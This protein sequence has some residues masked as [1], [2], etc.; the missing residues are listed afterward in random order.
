[1]ILKLWAGACEYITHNGQT[2]TLT[3]LSSPDGL[4][5]LHL[6]HADGSQS[7]NYLHTD[8]T[9]TTL[10]TGLGSWTTVTDETGTIVD[11]QSYD[12]WGNRRNPTTW[13][14]S[15]L[16]QAPRYDRGFTGHEH[17]GS[18]QLINP[19]ALHFI[20][21]SGSATANFSLHSVCEN[22]ASAGMNGRMYDPVTSRMLAPDNFVQTPDF[23]QNFNRYSYALN[24]PLM[25]TD[26]SGEL[27]WLIPNIGW[28][29]EGGLS[30][31]GSVVFGLPGA[32]SAQV[33][34]GYSFKSNDVY[35]YAGSTL[36]MN[37]VY[38]SVSSQSGWSAGYTA[39]LSPFSGLPISTNFG[40][41]GVNYNISH[42]SWT[43][44]VSAWQVDQN[45]W[46]FNPSVSVMVFPEQTTNL[47][48]GQG[49]RN[50]DAVL[51]RF[52]E[53]DNH[54]GALDYFGF[55]GKYNPDLKSKN[56]QSEDY[57]GATNRKTGKISYG[58]LAFEDYSTLYGIYIKESY[59]AQKIQSGLSIEELPSDLQGL[60]MDTYVEEIHGY[61]HAYK[62]QGLFYGHNMPFS[63]VEFYQSQLDV[64]GVPYPTYPSRFSW[65][66]KIHRRW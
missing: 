63:G 32:A 3:Y 42:N 38:T 66:Y 6:I 50:N 37:T 4:Y 2:A 56:Y 9:S 60:G 13:R 29:K 23:S 62:R 61:V 21:F 64:F 26:P 59:H 12:A 8:H 34:V 55:E 14:N 33:G 20:A 54:Q 16:W 48:R 65:I 35:G 24:N 5:G 17:L 49:F 27:L 22:Q 58:N 1:M 36:A 43:G 40:T 52:V 30:I 44:N 41:V 19:D 45:G 28:S 31:G 7:I 15:G 25:F 11:E 51:S 46:T 18:F 47:I 53:A 10:S 57:W 39:G